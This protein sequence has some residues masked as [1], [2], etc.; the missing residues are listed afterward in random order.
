MPGRKRWRAIQWLLPQATR[1]E[2]VI[3]TYVGRGRDLVAKALSLDG[4]HVIC[5]RRDRDGEGKL[6]STVGRK[7]D[8][9]STAVLGA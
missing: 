8:D 3:A 1:S 9:D 2:Y 5:G 6:A 7:R 4:R